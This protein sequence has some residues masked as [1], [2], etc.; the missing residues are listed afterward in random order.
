[1]KR[2][3]PESGGGGLSSSG[4]PFEDRARLRKAWRLA[5]IL[6]RAGA[7]SA[8]EVAAMGEGPRRLALEVWAAGVDGGPARASE[9]TW[10]EVGRLVGWMR[11]RSESLV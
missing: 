6:W 3:S 2:S 11:E 7:R 5:L 1:M 10:A 4:N 8:G 9:A